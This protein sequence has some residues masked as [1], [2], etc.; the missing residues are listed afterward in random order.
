MG[1][2]NTFSSKSGIIQPCLLRSVLWVALRIKSSL[3]LHTQGSNLRCHPM[4]E[5]QDGD[6]VVVR[7]LVQTQ[8][9]LQRV[10]QLKQ[11]ENEIWQSK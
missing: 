1:Y 2:Q 3:K 6:V 10:F 7:S 9:V 8:V 5:V 4:T 11:K